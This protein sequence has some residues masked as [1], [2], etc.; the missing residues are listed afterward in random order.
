MPEMSDVLSATPDAVRVFNE[1]SMPS[2][3]NLRACS[4]YVIAG[5][6][7]VAQAAS[8]RGAQNR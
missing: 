2:D 8:L 4:G 3:M 7:H 5:V 1:L 6:V